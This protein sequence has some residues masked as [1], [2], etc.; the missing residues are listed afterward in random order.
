MLDIL[1][2]S[3]AG[4]GVAPYFSVGARQLPNKEAM[5]KSTGETVLQFGLS[6]KIGVLYRVLVVC[7]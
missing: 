6:K 5:R 4:K 3:L 7:W 1:S 2:M